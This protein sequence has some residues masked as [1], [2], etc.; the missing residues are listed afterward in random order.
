MRVRRQRACVRPRLLIEP[1]EER[2]L[3]T[4]LTIITHGAEFLSTA[5]PGWLDAMGNAIRS[6]VGPDTSIYTIRVEP[7]GSGGVGVTQFSK[8][9]G[10]GQTSGSNGESILL[11]DW[12]AASD[13][14]ILTDVAD[15]SVTAVAAA[16]IPYLLAAKPSIGI[17]DPLAEGP[18]QIIGHSRGASLASVLATDL[19]QDGIWVDQ[20]TTLDPVPVPPDP[21]VSLKPN[22]IFADN[23]YE[24]NSLT[25]GSAVT[26]AYNVGPLSL[27]GAYGILDGGQHGDVHLF[28]DGT[29]N[30]AANASDGSE[31]VQ[32]SWYAGNH[33]TRDLTG[34]YYSRLDG[35]ARPAAGIGTPFGGKGARGKL[36]Y[37]GPQWPNLALVSAQFDTVSPGGTFAASYDYNSAGSSGTIQ[38]FLDPDTNAYDGNSIPISAAQAIAATGNGVYKGDVDLSADVPDGTYYL[39]GEIDNGAGTRY[40]YTTAI[41][42]TDVNTPP[43]G[44]L[45]VAGPATVQGWAMDADAPGVPL[46]V[47]LDVDGI[48]FASATANLSTSVPNVGTAPHGFNFNISAVPPGIHRIDLYAL[49][50]STGTPALIASQTISTNDPPTGK[51]TAIS[52]SGISGW[53][54]DAD[55]AGA[56]AAPIE[57]EY[58][59]DDGAP[60]LVTANINKASLKAKLHST[61]HGFSVRFPKLPAGKHAIAVYAVDATSDA[62]VLLANKT[63]NAG[64]PAGNPL[65][66]GAI[67]IWSATGISGWAYDP[68]VKAAAI[69]VRVDVDGVAGVP[70]EADGQATGLPATVVGADHGF[71]VP[72]NLPAGEHWVDVYAIDNKGAAV[73]MASQMIQVPAGSAPVGGIDSATGSTL[74]GWAYWAGLGDAATAALV[75]VDVDG[76]AGTVFATDVLRDDVNT[77]FDL[78]GGTFGFSIPMPDL[79]AGTHTL[80]LQFIDPLTLTTTAVASVPVTAS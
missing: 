38:W 48:L 43:T 3:L 30:L 68:S 11:L 71:I 67:S 40:A 39:E 49:D 76:V 31:T 33:L 17:A 14:N 51:I 22:V 10:P 45:T 60:V 20:V 58:Q 25:P 59:I 6:R 16:V 73:L 15:Y 57:I 18:I 28:Y 47:Q 29:I 44:G 42:V 56:G 27:G 35:G 66:Y 13:A 23:Y 78:A 41:T 8:L 36:T 9:S 69:D 1:L 70:V 77:Q 7:N 24:R 12:A 55:A 2:T 46:T 62:L 32:N 50:A 37:S 54:F 19:G 80:A 74:T 53:A 65:P 75:R 63:V 72:L 34:W 4:G 21:S 79:A 26:G 5:R 64:N 52:A 61:Q